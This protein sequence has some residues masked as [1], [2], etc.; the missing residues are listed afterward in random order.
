[1][2][3]AAADTAYAGVAHPPT[4][5]VTAAGRTFV[6]KPWTM[7]QRRELRPALAA[8]LEQIEQAS[9]AGT[10]IPANLAGLFLG[11][12]EQVAAVVRASVPRT[13]ISDDAWESMAWED[14]PVLAQAVWELNVQRGPVGKLIAGLQGRLQEAMRSA[15][16]K[17]AAAGEQQLGAD[18]APPSSAASEP[19]SPTPTSTGPRQPASPS[20]G[21]GG[22]PIPNA[23]AMP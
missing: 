5:E 8:L 18:P 17:A 16:E 12:E 9:Q 10:K 6:L 2:S 7:A 14:L 19:E 4:R 3:E 21:A 1:M 11:F 15:A 20:S 13:E 22:A 23:S